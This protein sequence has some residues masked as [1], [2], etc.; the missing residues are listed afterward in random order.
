MNRI[1]NIAH[2]EKN[3]AGRHISYTI[4]QLNP[5]VKFGI[6]HTMNIIRKK[7]SM[8]I[9]KLGR[10]EMNQMMMNIGEIGELE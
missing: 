9:P 6:L 10:R 2:D 1:S 8:K 5:E 4:N 7:T 3:S